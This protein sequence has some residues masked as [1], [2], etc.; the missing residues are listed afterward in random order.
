MMR[1]DPDCEENGLASV[2]QNRNFR[3][4]W[5]SQVFGQAAQNAI[6]FVLMVMVDGL[7]KSSALVGLMVLVFNLPSILFTM[8]LGVIVDRFRKKSILLFCNISRVFV[9]ASFVFFN[10]YARGGG[11]LTAVYVLT[12]ALSTIGHLSDPAESAMVPLL[13][14]PRQL[15]TANSVFHLL[16]NVAQV[17]GLLFLAPVSMKLGGVD[18]A[19]AAIA[20][21]YVVT[22]GL[23]WP[24]SVHESPPQHHS[25]PDALQ[26][27][28]EELQAG[29]KFIVS[30]RPVLT[31]IVQHA[32]ITM[33]TMIIAVLAPGFSARVLG[34]QPT[35][36]IYIFF[37]AGLGMFLTTLW[38][39]Q[40]GHRFRREALAAAGLLVIGLAL[41]G[42]TFIAWN[43]EMTPATLPKPSQQVIIQVVSM[44]LL[45]GVGGTLTAVATQTTVQERAPIEIRGRV[46]AAE[47]LFANIMG[48]IPMLIISGLADLV[49]IPAVLLGLSV[50]ILVSATLSIHSCMR[51]EV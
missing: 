37:S 10:R 32:L 28:W 46:I 5:V 23:I 15:L 43:A 51:R 12:F 30:R 4:L 26:Q 27:F 16:F 25:T 34:M 22:A 40:L 1:T 48:L 11:L 35:D 38:T 3:L 39:G 45:L 2:F 9:V 36:A 31:A 47:F 41:T 13:V 20:L 6:L 24:I 18:G 7:T 44:A 50:V 21:S 42:F 49:G 29:W 19:F 14:S 33:I 17:L 8:P